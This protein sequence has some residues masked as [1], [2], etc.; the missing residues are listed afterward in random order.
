MLECDGKVSD[1]GNSLSTKKKKIRELTGVGWWFAY[2]QSDKLVSPASV[3][4]GISL[5]FIVNSLHH[6]CW[7]SEKE[8]EEFSI[9]QVGRL[10]M[11]HCRLNNDFRASLAVRGVRRKFHKQNSEFL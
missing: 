5:S 8:N 1:S 4:T 7:K 11:V 2:S 6:F 9:S 3:V 10:E